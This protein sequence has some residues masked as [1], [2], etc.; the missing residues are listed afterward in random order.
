MSRKKRKHS[1]FAQDGVVDQ[2][3]S[4]RNSGLAST[5]AH[6]QAQPQNHKPK[7]E[8]SDSDNWTIIGKGGKKRKTNNYP[9]L[10]Y[11]DLHKQQSSIKINDLR[12]LVLYCIAHGTSPEWVSIRHHYGVKKAVVLFVP[13]LEKGMFDGS[14]ALE[15]IGNPEQDVEL[16]DETVPPAEEGGPQHVPSSVDVQAETPIIHS[17]TTSP[18]DYLPV[19]LA[20]ETLPNPLKPLAECFDYL[21]PVKAPG[22]DK[23]SKLFSPLHAMLNAPIPK[24]QE[25]KEA[26]KARK[27]AKP[28]NNQQWENKRTPINLFVLSKEELQESEYVLHPV[29]F[30]TESQTA[31]EKKRRKYSKQSPEH[32]WLDTHVTKLEDADVPA[33][34]VQQGTISAGCTVLAMDCEMCKTKEDGMALTRIS[35]VGWDGEVVMDELVKP[36]YP[37]TDYL[38]PF[39]GIT[40]EKLDPVTTTLADIQ[41]HLL[42]ILTPRTILVGHSLESD[43]HALKLTHPFIVDTSVLYQHPRGPPLKSSLKWLAQKY[44][45]REIQKGHGTLG[46]DSVEDSRA[47]LDL[48]KM[49]CEKGPEW[50]NSASSTET[51]FKRLSRTPQAGSAPVADGGQGKTGA[52]VDHGSPGKNFGHMATFSI[53]CNTDAEVVEGIK[54]AVLGDPDGALISG[55]GVDF[56]WARMR[57]LEALRGWSNNHRYDIIQMD[58]VLEGN[59]KSEPSSSEL[60]AKV[61]STVSHIRDV[62]ASLPPCTLLVVYTGTGDPRE[63]ARLQQMQRTYKRE[64]KVKKWDE[65]SVK[66]TDTEEQAMKQA[67]KKARQGLGF[68]TIT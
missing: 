14:V 3:E 68:V 7:A 13:G 40:A 52:I 66:W 34:G 22:D 5:L 57:E 36:D 42:E 53:G 54:R 32:G 39:S 29:W 26:E 62:R 30:D 48:V 38:T 12:T 45:N 43:L 15:S 18:D 21:W 10:I 9:A 51:I 11:A 31:T 16:S 33:Q 65:L 23:F 2:G 24:S 61:A 35:L 17:P 8:D 59:G 50:G 28:V 44:L 4:T 37:I 67:C 47:C 64:Y 56:T 25:Q 1:Q 60:A 58:H 55:G 46:H 27:G 19:R 20:P 63:L 6:L 49:K 41:K